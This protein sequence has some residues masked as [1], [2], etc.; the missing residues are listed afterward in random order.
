MRRREPL[1]SQMGDIAEEQGRSTVLDR[2]LT[3]P[4]GKRILLPALCQSGSGLYTTEMLRRVFSD[5]QSSL[6]I[7]GET[8]SGKEALAECTRTLSGRDPKK[9]RTINCAGLQPNLADSELF[10]HVRGA[11]TDAIEDRNGLVSECVDGVLFL[12]EI[13][14]LDKPLQ[15]KL[16]RF[17]QSGE[18]RRVGSNTVEHA[19]NVLVIAA[20]NLD[21]AAVILPDLIQRFDHWLTIPPLRDRGSDALWFLSQ[22]EF[23]KHQSTFTGISLRTLIGVLCCRW[24]GNVR[25][26][27]KYCRAK[28][29]LRSCEVGEPNEAEYILD[30]D[31]LARSSG[32]SDW[33]H[34]ANYILW[35]VENK[36]GELTSGATVDTW[37]GDE[38]RALTLGL[39]ENIGDWRGKHQ[40]C[41]QTDFYSPGLTLPIDDLEN[42]LCSPHSNTGFDFFAI[43]ALAA[44]QGLVRDEVVLRARHAHDLATALEEIRSLVLSFTSSRDTEQ[45]PQAPECRCA[46]ST[47]LRARIRNLPVVKAMQTQIPPLGGESAVF[48]SVLGR[49]CLSTEEQLICRLCHDRLS[50]KEIAGDPRVSMKRSTVNHFLQTMRRKHSD[51]APHIEPQ[52]AGR[53]HTAK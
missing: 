33:A 4:S 7:G 50:G 42:A 11:F 30:D 5:G 51:L 10:G 3:L 21:I 34:F 13:G 15:A 46:P 39:L 17:M 22:A 40:N 9:C 1:T 53:K 20:T 47:A 38:S 41:F 44:K 49:L 37:L 29:K 8:G 2:V 18:Y 24:D 45:R 23:L 32:F 14:W 35:V 27:Q 43:A 6:L 48:E 52:R 26:L 12:D 16:L 25:E 28:V 19:E 36:P 31:K